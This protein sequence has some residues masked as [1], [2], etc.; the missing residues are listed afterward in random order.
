MGVSRNGVL[1]SFWTPGVPL[2]KHE[3]VGDYIFLHN[4]PAPTA[5]FLVFFLMYQTQHDYLFGGQEICRRTHWKMEISKS[6]SNTV[7]LL[8]KS[9]AF[10]LNIFATCWSP[11]QIFPT[12]SQIFQYSSVSSTFSF[13]IFFPFFP[14]NYI[15]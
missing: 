13:P 11:F 7:N 12:A 2:M 1:Q 9:Y 10:G 8:Y 3:S 15:K 14:L 4:I 6:H 5:S